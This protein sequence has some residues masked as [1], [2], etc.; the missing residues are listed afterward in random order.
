MVYAS[1][2]SP[3]M[4]L[5]KPFLAKKKR[6][7]LDRWGR[8]DTY[9]KKYYEPLLNHLNEEIPGHLHNKRYPHMWGIEGHLYRVVR[10]L[11]ASEVLTY[12]F[13][14]YFKDKSFEELDDIAA[15]FKLENCVQRAELNRILKEDAQSS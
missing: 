13:A 7:G 14:S 11:F 2:D 12:E 10:E 9:A 5:L 8:D 15:S 6:M 3:Y 1:P 4:N